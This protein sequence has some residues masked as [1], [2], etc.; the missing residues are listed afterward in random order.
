VLRFAPVACSA[1]STAVDRSQ[2]RKRLAASKDFAFCAECGEK[3]TL[4]PA[5]TPVQLTEEVKRQLNAE[6]TTVD[7]RVI[8]EGLAYKLKSHADA[9]GIAPKRCFMSYAW[10]D[11]TSGEQDLPVEKWV[12]RLADDLKQS[13]HNVILDQTHNEHYG[14]SIAR[15]IEKIAKCERVLV[16]GTPLYLR[17]YENEDF[18]AG[19]I[20]AAEMDLV[21][22]RLT[23]TE[24]DKKSVIGMLLNGKPDESLPPLLRG[25]TYADFRD[26]NAYFVGAFDLM[27]TLYGLGFSLPGIVEWRQ[28][29]RGHR[30]S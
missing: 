21:A 19:T 25:R 9:E 22:Q 11:L 27:L 12:A 13:G 1:C 15:F 24:K 29:L 4:P 17:K 20:V 26:E 23:G 30:Q 28:T 14:Q 18:E 8:F 7:R 2:I 5:D 3:L 10:R 16:A 6:Q